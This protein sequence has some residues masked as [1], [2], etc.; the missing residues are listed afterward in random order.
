ML[1]RTVGRG[2]I[3]ASGWQAADIAAE[4]RI[5]RDARFA[6]EQYRLD[7]D[8]RRKRLAST[9]QPLLALLED[10]IIEVSP[11][12]ASIKAWRR[13]LGA[14]IAY[15]GHDDACRVTFQ[16][17]DEWRAQLLTQPTASGK[18]LSTKTVRD[19]YLSILKT[20]FGWAREKR[21][22]QDNPTEGVRVRARSK[23]TFRPE[24]GLSDAEATLIL[25]STTTKSQSRLSPKRALARRWVPW[26]CA[27]TGARVNE[28]TQLR[29]RDVFERNG[30]W[31][32]RITPDAGGV[33]NN[34]VRL[35]PLHP[36]LIEQGFL[37]AISGQRDALFG[38]PALHRGGS[39]GNPQYKKVGEYLARWV[40]EI[41][42]KDPEVQ[43]SH[44]WRHRFTTQAR[45]AGME[46]EITRAIQGHAA[47]TEGEKYGYTP[48]EA[49]WREMQKLPSFRWL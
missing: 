30:M 24:R 3:E 43:P 8:R 39:D 2:Q 9:P 41:G 22:I 29:G 32:I 25:R 44:G 13:Q 16:N 38:D 49:M 45:L 37:Q 7:A 33:K 12:P 27:Y 23:P 20:I 46:T 6:P 21:R 18:V 14:F 4:P 48:P 36:H 31:V 17:V 28:I 35:V 11:A 15:L 47:R 34:R 19:T 5:V 40:R 42:V 10:Y 26:I 1:V